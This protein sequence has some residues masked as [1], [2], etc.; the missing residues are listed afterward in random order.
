MCLTLIKQVGM[1]H[2]RIHTHTHTLFLGLVEVSLALA[3]AMMWVQ[4][5]CVVERCLR[6]GWQR[7]LS[8]GNAAP[9]LPDPEQCHPI[10]PGHIGT[11]IPIYENHT[12]T[13][14]NTDAHTHTQT[15]EHH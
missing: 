3:L 8:F 10:Y 7:D 5:C 14:R 15:K 11:D 6:S 4:M 2:S 12:H 9:P 13:H 1:H